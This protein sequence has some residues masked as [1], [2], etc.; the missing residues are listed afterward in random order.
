MTKFRLRLPSWTP[1][2]ALVFLWVVG[3]TIFVACKL[4]GQHP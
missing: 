1:A 4:W 2:D 3:V